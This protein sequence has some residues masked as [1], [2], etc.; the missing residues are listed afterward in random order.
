MNLITYI[1]KQ[2]NCVDGLTGPWCQTG[3]HYYEI[4]ESNEEQKEPGVLAV[5]ATRKL[6]TTKEEAIEGSKRAFDLF[7]MHRMGKLYWRI[8]PKLEWNPDPSQKKCRIR[9]RLIISS[10]EPKYNST[11]E[12]MKAKAN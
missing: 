7:S 3:D 9:M 12:V 11:E 4:G 1:E 10:K 8:K 2:F 5:G 6:Y